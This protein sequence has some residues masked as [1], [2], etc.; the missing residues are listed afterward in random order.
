VPL[1]FDDVSADDVELVEVLRGS[2]ADGLTWRVLAGGNVADLHTY[3]DRHLD[4]ASAMSGFRGPALYPGE[5]V[6]SWGGQADGLPEFVMVRTSPTVVAV[7]V[8][9]ATGRE[10]P[11]TLSDVTERFGLRFGAIPVPEGES[12]V[13]LRL[14]AASGDA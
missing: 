10:Y 3:V 1:A 8:V 7:T 4:D 6:N 2:R 14:E 9:S 11:V 12:V 5:L 13:E